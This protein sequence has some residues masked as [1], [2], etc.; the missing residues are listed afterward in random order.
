MMWSD[1]E[2]MGCTGLVCIA[3]RMIT[4]QSPML[5]RAPA[6]WFS[7]LLILF[8]P[9]VGMGQQPY[10]WN[11]T[12]EDN[13]PS[14]TVWD[15]MLDHSGKVWMA[16]AG[17]LAYH[18]GNKI[19]PVYHVSDQGRS[20]TGLQQ[21]K[22]GRIWCVDFG[23]NP[24]YVEHDTVFP[25][26]EIKLDF[27]LSR[28]GITETGNV[29]FINST[30]YRVFDP[31]ARTFTPILSLGEGAGVVRALTNDLFINK[32]GYYLQKGDSMVFHSRVIDRES[33]FFNNPL[34]KH[35]QLYIDTYSGSIN[36]LKGDTLEPIYHLFHNQEGRAKN[37]ILAHLN[38]DST[39]WFGTN[40][41][42]FEWSD[43]HRH[44]LP[45]MRVSKALIDREGN[46]WFSTLD[47]GV[48]VFP[49]V[50]ATIYTSR[51][52]A[53]FPDNKI[54]RLSDGPGSLIYLGGNG[55]LVA[56]DTEERSYRTFHADTRK[57]CEG[58]TYDASHA[59]IY[60]TFGS[61]L[62]IDTG[63]TRV[64]NRLNGNLKEIAPMEHLLA[65]RNSKSLN[66]MARLPQDSIHLSALPA[67]DFTLSPSQQAP[68]E[69]IRIGFYAKMLDE[70]TIRGL[71]IDQTTG[72]LVTGSNKR[73]LVFDDFKPRELKHNGESIRGVRVCQN[74]DGS[75]LIITRQKWLLHYHDGILSDLLEDYPSLKENR[76]L[77]A[78]KYG[79][80][81]FAADSKNLI[82]L[83]PLSKTYEVLGKLDG[84]PSNDINDVLV[85]SGHIWLATSQGLVAYPLSLTRR[86]ET[87]P[88]TT[89][90]SIQI[91]GAFMDS[92]RKTF[93]YTENSFTFRI[94]ANCYRSRKGFQYRY[95]LL[96]QSD[97]WITQGSGQN[98]LQF[99]GLPANDYRLEVLAINEDGVEGPITSFDFKVHPPFW[100]ALWFYL[101]I[102]A[103]VVLILFQLYRY[104][105]RIMKR[106]QQLLNQLT[107]SKLTAIRAQMNPHFMFNALNSIQDLVLANDFET[108]NRFLGMFSDLMR[109]VLEH[110][111]KSIVP[112]KEELRLLELY[113]ELES[114]RFKDDFSYEIILNHIEAENQISIVPLVIQPYVENALKHGLLHK[115][116]KKKV[117]IELTKGEHLMCVIT[118][119]GIGRVK[120]KEI[121]ERQA[122][123]HASFA[124]EANQSRLELL[125]QLENENFTEIITDLYDAAGTATGTEVRLQ[126]PII[127]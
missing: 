121:K 45:G 123:F 9:I 72:Q 5:S 8:L 67:P 59:K 113:L 61:L 89:I 70:E 69:K 25:F 32:D 39:F 22:T 6:S 35:L 33:F 73:T 30:H 79:D 74:D 106:R 26:R 7:L 86:N 12:E 105:I 68:N 107:E 34:N 112:L 66:L 3:G 52:D 14:Q 56:F 109:K 95:R 21:D 126:L 99:S 80:T 124:T 31:I 20:F 100:Q 38:L 51:F 91:N 125:S 96:G 50:E 71:G 76:F 92:I 40:N 77:V 55:H 122:K 120:A 37:I 16:T 114:L 11:I 41:G 127:G 88:Q 53:D 24:Y 90:T 46:H 4:L 116:G 58:I 65:F 82:A 103:I 63:L 108:T 81:I 85:K 62:E 42:A 47:N 17:G 60:A 43:S 118:D 2:R 10:S 83:Y 29:I 1:R 110:S 93:Q 84:I 57:E 119:N 49:S 27:P 117:T 28:V 44:L 75:V 64:R 98:T 101:V 36:R 102:A 111:N 15:L 54:Y 104:R 115:E 18:D 87:R 19:V 78:R 94:F 48:F 97:Q 23:M 13:L